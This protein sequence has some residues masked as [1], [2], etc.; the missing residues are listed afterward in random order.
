MGAYDKIHPGVWMNLTPEVASTI[1]RLDFLVALFHIL[2]YR[3]NVFKIGDPY[4]EKMKAGLWT[5]E[6]K[7][8]PIIIHTVEQALRTKYYGVGCTF[9]MGGHHRI[10]AVIQSGCTIYSPVETPNR[11]FKKQYD[12]LIKQLPGLLRELYGI[13]VTINQTHLPEII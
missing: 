8:E 7:E 12:E 1:Y 2:R 13:D 11:D 6:I 5:T 9:L 4:A 3:R 10:P